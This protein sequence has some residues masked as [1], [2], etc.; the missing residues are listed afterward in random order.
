MEDI[1]KL[2]M[3]AKK[4]QWTSVH[5]KNYIR[6]FKAKQTAQFLL[7]VGDLLLRHNWL[8]GMFWA[9]L[10]QKISSIYGLRRLYLQL[11]NKIGWT[12]ML[13]FYKDDADHRL[14]VLR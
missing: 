14:W 9:D 6:Y 7:G 8:A 2:I 1:V 4:E 12:F 5:T 10:S 3:T 11:W 13:P